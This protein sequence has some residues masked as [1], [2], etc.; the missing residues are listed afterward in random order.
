MRDCIPVYGSLLNGGDNG[1]E[2]FGLIYVKAKKYLK[3]QGWP[4]DKLNRFIE[5]CFL[6][7]LK[8]FDFSTVLD[9]NTLLV[10]V[11]SS[12]GYNSL[13][14]TF[15]DFLGNAFGCLTVNENITALHDVEAKNSR[16]LFERNL[17]NLAY[18]FSNLGSLVSIC[19]ESDKVILVDDIITTGDSMITLGKQLKVLGFPVDGMMGLIPQCIDYPSETDLTGI[20]MTIQRKL[21][22]NTNEMLELTAKV[23]VVFG[24]YLYRRLKREKSSLHNAAKFEVE[25][26]YQSIDD[27]YQLHN[28]L[29]HRM[30]KLKIE[31]KEI[32]IFK[33]DLE[34]KIKKPKLD[35]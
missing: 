29:M 31:N 19:N 20:T 12:S 2:T 25:R 35:L 28:A 3:E 7:Q 9:E 30:K 34:K 24:E 27:A 11:P 18:N 5:Y 1:P 16:R 33:R 23:A 26:I 17:S 32:L 15:L 13:T 10:M 22:L 21:G 6:R 4:Q 14:T 8:R